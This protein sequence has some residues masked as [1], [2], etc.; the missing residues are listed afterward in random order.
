MPLYFE[1]P[2]GTKDLLPE[3]VRLNQRVSRKAQSFI[4]T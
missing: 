3:K 1:K 2:T 4:E